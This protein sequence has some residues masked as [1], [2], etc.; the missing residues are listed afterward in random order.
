MG[1]EEKRA[2]KSISIKLT[3]KPTS[4]QMTILSRIGIGIYIYIYYEYKIFIRS[5]CCS[6]GEKKFLDG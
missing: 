6:E 3:T 5:Y 4:V 1:K 2:Q